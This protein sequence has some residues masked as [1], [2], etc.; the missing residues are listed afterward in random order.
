MPRLLRSVASMPPVQV[1]QTLLHD[2]H[3]T[4]SSL[5]RLRTRAK[6]SVRRTTTE[7]ARFTDQGMASSAS[8]PLP[9]RLGGDTPLRRTS[10]PRRK[11]RGTSSTT[12]YDSGG[13][14]YVRRLRRSEPVRLDVL[15][16]KAQL[17]QLYP[18]KVDYD[19]ER[20]REIAEFEAELDGVPVGYGRPR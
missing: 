1:L 14:A 12:K 2:K 8:L 13:D 11:P 4:N 6:P 3:R 9:E 7:E 5:S 10:R 16:T 15:L 20:E 18:Q 17:Q 19:A